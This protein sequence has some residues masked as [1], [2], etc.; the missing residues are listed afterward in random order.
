[1]AWLN[2]E[3]DIAS[4]FGALALCV[5]AK[6]P[7]FHRAHQNLTLVR[8]TTR[9]ELTDDQKETKRKALEAGRR[10]YKTGKQREYDAREKADRE[11]ADMRDPAKMAKAFVK[12]LKREK[13]L[14]QVEMMC[15]G[16]DVPED[17]TL[18]HE[19]AIPG[20]C[21]VRVDISVVLFVTRGWTPGQ[22]AKLFGPGFNRSDVATWLEGRNY[23]VLPEPEEGDTMSP[24][25]SPRSPA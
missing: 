11:A 25:P 16:R 14:K 15:H 13:L 20:A 4:A 22:I 12:R 21:L 9:E 19:G 10:A 3:E 7:G 6:N 23:L 2:L 5:P 18:V 17:A 24:C 8:A 1:V